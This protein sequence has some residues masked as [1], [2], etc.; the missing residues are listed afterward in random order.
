MYVFTIN[1]VTFLLILI[2]YYIGCPPS[3]ISSVT[4][5]HSIYIHSVLHGELYITCMIQELLLLYL[6]KLYFMGMQDEKCCS[7]EADIWA[8]GM[9]MMKVLAGEYKQIE[10]TEQV[11]CPYF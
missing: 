11:G 10:A 5:M 9:T 8:G 7:T 2:G 4:L 3:D 1:L 6:I